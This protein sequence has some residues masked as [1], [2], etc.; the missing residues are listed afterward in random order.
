[1]ANVAYLIKTSEKSSEELFEANNT[2]PLFWL[3]L[4]DLALIEKIEQDLI[5]SYKNNDDEYFTV[6]ISKKAFIANLYSGKKFVEKNYADK[7][8]LYNDFT[9]YLD[10]KFSE[11]DVL[12]LNILEMAN[13][14]GIKNLVKGITKIIININANVKKLI[15]FE[16]NESIFSFVGYDG[17][18]ANEFRNYSKDY[19]EYCRN[20]EKE[21]ELNKKRIETENKKSKLK[22]L[23][24]NIGLCIVGSI[25]LFIFIF[26]LIKDGFNIMGIFGIAFGLICTAFGILKLKGIL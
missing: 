11:N 9:N 12:E 23:V 22:E 3:N 24:S 19:F 26:E 1:M 4:V 2:I 10:K 7:I 6:K 15:P 21:R 16:P 8:N 20:E 25:F 13:F 5:N 18:L 17:F 14:I